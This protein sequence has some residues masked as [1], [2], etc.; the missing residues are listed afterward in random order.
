MKKIGL[1]ILGIGLIITLI[2]GFSFVTREKV[3]DIGDL[4]ISRNK[5]HSYAWSPLVGVAIMAIGGG[6]FLFGIKKK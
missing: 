2:A 6:V 5:S 3:V 4:N 1:I